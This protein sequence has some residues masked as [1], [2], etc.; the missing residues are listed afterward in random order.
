MKAARKTGP[1]LTTDNFIKAM[2]L[3]TFPPD[4]FGSP[5]MSFT[6]KKRLGSDA[7]RLSQI[8]DGRWKVVSGY[9]SETANVADAAQS[10]KVVKAVKASA[11]AKQ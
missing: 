4:S 10:A 6:A 8:T 5:K 1:N 9:V 2:D 11:P 3:S 7:L